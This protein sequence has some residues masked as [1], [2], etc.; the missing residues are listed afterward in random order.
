MDNNQFTVKATEAIT[1]QSVLNS[2]DSM[3]PR[4]LSTHI[5]KKNDLNEDDSDQRV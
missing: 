4:G 5:D 1:R 3:G 2:E